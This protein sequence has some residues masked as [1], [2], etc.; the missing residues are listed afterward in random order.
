MTVLGAAKS[1]AGAVTITLQEAMRKR[2]WMQNRFRGLIQ[3]MPRER[4]HGSSWAATYIKSVG[5]DALKSSK[6]NKWLTVDV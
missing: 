1:L 3:T 2:S 6:E 4:G 5:P